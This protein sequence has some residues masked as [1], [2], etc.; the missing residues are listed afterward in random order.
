VA[1]RGVCV[2]STTRFA[3]RATFAP[4]RGARPLTHSDLLSGEDYERLVREV[5]EST[6]SA[7]QGTLDPATERVMQ[8]VPNR[9]PAAGLHDVAAEK[10]AALIV[11]GSSHRSGLGRVFASSIAESALAGAPVP[12]AVGPP[13]L[14][15]SI[16]FGG[17][18]SA[19]VGFT[20]VY[21]R[22]DHATSR[23]GTS[24]LR[25]QTWSSVASTA[26]AMRSS[27]GSAAA[28]RFFAYG[29]GTSAMPTRSTGASRSSKHAFWMR[30]A[31]SAVTP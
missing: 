3:P 23:S 7:A 20:S 5:A 26:R 21:V 29:S 25:S 8:L 19:G 12:V 2:R 28:S 10:G 9:S 15:G 30:A 22:D 16:A 17:V 4:G 13:G 31:S 18:S 24:V 14:A 11:V 27:L 1:S 6:L